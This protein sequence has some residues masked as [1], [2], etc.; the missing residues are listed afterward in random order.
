MLLLVTAASHR[1]AQFSLVISQEC[2]SLVV[3]FAQRGVSRMAEEG[4][5]KSEIHVAL[6]E[7]NMVSFATV[8]V[9][10]ALEADGKSILP[11]AFSAAR[12]FFCPRFWPFC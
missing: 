6:A 8:M 12:S 7:S 5:L 3:D 9:M 11:A 1:A 4:R 10:E 2:L